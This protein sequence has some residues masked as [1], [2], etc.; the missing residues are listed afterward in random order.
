MAQETRGMSAFFPDAA[1]LEEMQRRG[2]QQ[3]QRPGAQGWQS[4][5]TGAPMSPRQV[6]GV[7]AGGYDELGQAVD[8]QG[9]VIV[10]EQ[11]G[12][13][14]GYNIAGYDEL[15][16]AVDSQGRVIIPDEEDLTG[17][18]IP[19]DEGGGGSMFD[20][21]MQMVMQGSQGMEQM[22]G[23]IGSSYDA[24]RDAV[25]GLIPTYQQA[26]GKATGA[27]GDYFGYASQ[28][29]QAGRGAVAESYTGAQDQVGQIYDR[30]GSSLEALPAE[31]AAMA[32]AA[33][34]APGAAA[35]ESA[36]STV[37]PFMAAG[38]SSRANTQANLTQRSAAAQGYLSNLAS[39]SSA[40]AAQRQSA[41]E[42]ELMAATQGVQ[43][44][45]AEIE[46]QKQRALLE[47]S[48]DHS[49]DVFNRML[50]VMQMQL[51]YDQHG[52][53]RERFEHEASAQ[54]GMDLSDMKNLL[55]IER[56]T[57]PYA[58]GGQ[59]GA[60]MLLEG[61]TPEG[62][63]LYQDVLSQ[64]QA[65]PTDATGRV[66]SEEELMADA[67]ALLSG[68]TTETEEV[69]DEKWWRPGDQGRT[70]EV[71]LGGLDLYEGDPN[72]LA[73]LQEAFRAMYGE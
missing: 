10:P 50:D 20:Q 69:S 6:H 67:L 73:L 12:Q 44:R 66:K 68:Y 48:A 58:V 52:L 37:A 8:E 23:Q 54:G 13:V 31:V 57:D 47:Y 43:A 28:Q 14:H 25:L 27:M 35:G 65:A 19:V 64:V 34:G 32:Q 7:T 18:K 72:D 42:S 5:F 39:A 29:A 46:G 60:N 62:Q 40:E 36:A 1:M 11:L 41:V 38:E 55:D 71:P 33:S 61:V 17:R 63:A 9:R 26:A 53:A 45:A 4:L 2:G 21:L 49:G 15:G 51:A 59:R 24:Q 22:Q 70:K 16:Q 30:L 3:Q 56:M